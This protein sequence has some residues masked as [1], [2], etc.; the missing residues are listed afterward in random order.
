MTKLL[1]SIILSCSAFTTF[2]QIEEADLIGKW[3]LTSSSNSKWSLIKAEEYNKKEIPDFG[4]FIEFLENKT[5]HQYASAQC[6]LDDN[7]YSFNGTW[8]LDENGKIILFFDLNNSYKRPNIY[9]NY[10]LLKKG[11]MKVIDITKDELTVRI[12]KDWEILSPKK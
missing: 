7:N 5:Y 2:S 9:Y 3:K 8:Q 1:Y 4:V 6:G 12:V 11:E 10:T